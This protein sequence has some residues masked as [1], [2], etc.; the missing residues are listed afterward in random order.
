MTELR[1]E[2]LRLLTEDSATHDMRHQ[3][4]NQALFFA[5]NGHAIWTSITLDMIMDKF[6]RAAQEMARKAV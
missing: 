4:F 6:D 1:A 3:K 5:D 2:F